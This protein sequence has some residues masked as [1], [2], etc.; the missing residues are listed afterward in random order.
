MKGKKALV[1]G[2]GGFIG[3]HLVKRLKAEGCFVRGIDLKHPEFY[4][5]QA[6]EFIIGDLRNTAITENAL[7]IKGGFDEVFQMAA[8][9]GGAKFIF[10]GNHD[11]D[12]FTNSMQINLNV[13][14]AAVSYGGKKLFYSS[15]ACIY[16]QD[17]QIN[18]KA[19]NSLRESDAFPANPDSAY[20]WEKIASEKLYQAY[21]RNYGLDI[22]IARFHNIYGIEGT[23]EGERAK[24]PAA[25]CTKI[26]K[27]GNGDSIE[28]WGDGEQ[29]RSFCFVDDCVDGVMRL[30]KSDYTFPINI[31]SDRLISIND[32]A[33]MV[34][35]ISGKA[36]TIKNVES[37]SL[38]VRGRNSDNTLIKKILDWVPNTPLEEGMRKTYRWIESQLTKEFMKHTG[39]NRGDFA[40][41]EYVNTQKQ[42]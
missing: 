28:V 3:S 18:A 4:P 2:A 37:D 13:A 35:A 29:T 23:Y 26:A 42:K 33:K 39:M 24:A 27:A 36:I 11:A 25:I 21:Q 19:N 6:D 30:M 12:L 9:M 5:T 1:C 31:G 15:S 20:G 38:G 7:R 41:L 10:S 22:R 16:P 32:L 40:F 8:D 14:E 34:I 17:L